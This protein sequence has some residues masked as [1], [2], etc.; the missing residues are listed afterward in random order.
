MEFSRQEYWSEL[1]FPFPGDLPHPGIKPRSPAL[2]AAS[3]LSKPPGKSFLSHVCIGALDIFLF[4][5]E[6][7]YFRLPCFHNITTFIFN[8]M[9]DIIAVFLKPHQFSKAAQATRTR[10]HWNFGFKAS[11]TLKIWLISPNP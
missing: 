6:I 4:Q 9:E 1:P 3:L 2:Q 11:T 5:A 10:L 7:S 8:G